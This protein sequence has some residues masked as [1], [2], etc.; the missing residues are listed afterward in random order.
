MKKY[1][2]K[3]IKKIKSE[4]LYILNE[5]GRPLNH[6]QIRQKI[7][8]KE[9][10]KTD[11]LALLH[12][13]V[14]QKKILVNENFKFYCKKPH[15]RSS[16]KG[17]LEF[18]DKKEFFCR[19][20]KSNNLVHVPKKYLKG[21]LINDCVLIKTSRNKK[22][23]IIGK[24]ENITKRFKEFFVGTFSK[25][26]NTSFVLPF[27]K[28]LKTDFYIPSGKSLNANNND[29]VVVRL[30]E[31]PE[32]AKCPFGEIT[33]IIGVSGDFSSELKSIIRKHGIAQNFSKETLS[34][35]KSLGVAIKNEDIVN[36]KDFRE[37]ACFTIDPEDAKDFDDALSVKKLKKNIF[38]IG[39]HI[40]DVSHYVRPNTMIDK[41]AVNRGCSVY[42]ADQVIPM[43]PEKLANKLCSL[44]PLEDKLCFSII[45]NIN[46]KGE[47]LS[48]WAG[49]TIIKSKKRFTYH[50]AQDVLNKKTGDFYDELYI[51]DNIA[52]KLRSNR[53]KNGSVIIEKKEIRIQFDNGEPIRPYFKESVET[54]KLIEEFMLLANQFVC[55]YFNKEFS[56]I[57]RVHDYPDFEKLKA[58]TTFLKTIDVNFNFNKKNLAQSINELLRLVEKDDYKYLINQLILHSMAKAEYSTKNIGHFGLGFEN[59]SHFT[60]PIR[61]YPDILVHRILNDSLSRKK[62]KFT[63][64]ESLCRQ[65]SKKERFAVKAEREYMR[66]L[67]LWLVKDQIGQSTIATITSIKEWG[68]YAELDKYLCEGMIS[69]SS[70]KSIGNF[71]HNKAKNEMINKINGETLSL[72]QKLSVEIN[73]INIQRGELDLIIV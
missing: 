38:E 20:E 30:L 41:D 62:T 24:V 40:A 59:Y 65:S 60:S 35:V 48:N 21:A 58:I 44:R 71:Y 4:I 29:R 33:E 52:K 23:N 51:L 15:S 5:V 53:I 46:H 73:N 39:V 8:I 14:N 61:R 2:D 49:K 69:L 72:G 56:G 10:K 26:N 34:Y 43:L 64:L 11:L 47:V 68:V 42:L 22:G 63:N 13:L 66:F 17:N 70:L 1:K 32:G 19:C 50:Q 12:D 16:I 37:H 67:L 18:G 28:N 57:Y 31:W 6:K 54:N 36:R 45:F 3:K 55:K 27:D 9:N 7:T 25:K